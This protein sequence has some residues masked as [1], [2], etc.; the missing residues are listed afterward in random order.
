MPRLEN[1]QHIEGLVLEDIGTTLGD[2]LRSEAALQ[3]SHNPIPSLVRIDELSNALYG[4]PEY[5]VTEYGAYV[6]GRKP[7]GSMYDVDE[8]NAM[9][10]AYGLKFDKP[11]PAAALDIMVERKKLEQLRQ[12]ISSSGPRAP[13]LKFFTGLAVSVADPLNAVVSFIPVIGEA[14]Y[15]SLVA[16]LGKVGA[17]SVRGVVEGA[18]GAVAVEPFILA[19]ASQE[20]SDY[21]MMDSLLNVTFGSIMGGGLHVAGGAAGDFLKL[22]SLKGTAAKV[23]ALD[24]ELK[25]A[26]LRTTIAQAETD[27]FPNPELILRETPQFKPV[28]SS[29]PEF[30]S[31]IEGLATT[32]DPVH[33]VHR[34]FSKRVDPGDTVSGLTV[35]EGVPNESSIDGV[36]G[37]VEVLPGIREIPIN[38]VQDTP[39]K[40]R[41]YS[42]DDIRRVKELTEAIDASKEITPLIVVA[43][44]NGYMYV[45]EGGHRIEALQRLGVETFPAKVVVDMESV[46]ARQKTQSEAQVADAPQKLEAEARR[47]EDPEQDMFA[48][49]EPRNVMVEKAA[50]EP[51]AT[52]TAMAST[53]ATEAKANL[54]ASVRGL[55]PEVLDALGIDRADIE[56]SQIVKDTESVI[57]RLKDEATII[58]KLTD[59]LRGG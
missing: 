16:K 32:D 15:A 2:S 50:G 31:K 40:T 49:R 14:R 37:D 18:V 34:A 39:Y 21:E 10:E 7:V 56:N 44:E 42:T 26:A 22:R 33:F 43:E 4:E 52:D 17:R 29:A 46:L 9:G 25:A 45:L 5:L 24:M 36:S 55:D 12:S 19:A 23:E 54:E 35:R 8:A 51:E 41:Y 58:S 47:I 6:S 48:V 20:Q 53:F 13:I 38:E 27:V 57:Q 3:W 1:N 28:E 59:C 11:I 30:R